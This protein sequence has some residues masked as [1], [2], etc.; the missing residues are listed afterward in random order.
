MTRRWTPRSG[1]SPRVNLTMKQ[2]KSKRIITLVGEAFPRNPIISSAW[3]KLQN[4]T[5][6]STVLIPKPTSLLLIICK[7]QCL[8]DGALVRRWLKF[9]FWEMIKC[10]IYQTSTMIRLEENQAILV[11]LYCSTIPHVLATSWNVMKWLFRE[12]NLK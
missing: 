7:C 10:F 12:S 3:C 1:L 2:M 4:I 11:L 9:A 6:D 8:L 5:F